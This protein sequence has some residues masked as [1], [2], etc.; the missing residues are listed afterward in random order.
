[1]ELRDVMLWKESCKSF[2][3]F[4]KLSFPFYFTGGIHGAFLN[5]SDYTFHLNSTEGRSWETSTLL[6]QN[7]SEGDL[8]SIEEEEERNFVRNIIKKTPSNKIFYR[9]KERQLEMEMVDQSNNS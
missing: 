3:D 8:G 6:C 4:C 9:L 7:S 1:M 2:H 5:C